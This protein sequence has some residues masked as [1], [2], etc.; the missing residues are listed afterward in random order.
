MLYDMTLERSDTEGDSEDA[1][2]GI[3]EVLGGRPQLTDFMKGRWRKHKS[4][5]HQ[6]IRIK[7]KDHQRPSETNNED[8]VGML[9]Y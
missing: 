7:S 2:L 4:Q 9:E 5:K 1:L 6:E 8:K 3:E